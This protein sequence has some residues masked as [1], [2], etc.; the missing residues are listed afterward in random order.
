MAYL[1]NQDPNTKIWTCREQYSGYVH[2]S[3][4][5]KTKEEALSKLLEQKK[6]INN[7]LHTPY[8]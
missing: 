8:Y 3:G 7:I 2:L 6:N 4:T 5:G 1:Y